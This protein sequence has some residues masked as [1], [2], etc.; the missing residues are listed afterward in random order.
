MNH[1]QF[2]TGVNMEDLKPEIDDATAQKKVA[3]LS[4]EFIAK[5]LRMGNNNNIRS[6]VRRTNEIFAPITAAF[7]LE[8]DA[9]FNVPNQK[10]APNNNCPRG[11]CPTSSEWIKTAQSYI[12]G[13]EVMR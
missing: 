5:Q 8:G 1:M 4:V 2:G 7:E 6:E 10:S 3:S 11:V 12:L 13:E 9:K